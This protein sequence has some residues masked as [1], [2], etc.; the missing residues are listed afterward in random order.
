MFRRG[1]ICAA[2]VPLPLISNR[3]QTVPTPRIIDYYKTLAIPPD[4]DLIGVENAYVRLSDELVQAAQEEEAAARSLQVLNEAY[5]VLSNAETRREYDRLLFAEEYA[6]LER[7]LRA[8]LRRRAIARSALVA[9]LG[10]IVLGQAAILAYV[11]RD[12][13]T[14]AAQVVL[15]PLFPGAA[16]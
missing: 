12:I 15:G 1:G 14:D 4:A 7:R 3:G 16:G 6:A 10:L 5:S 8:E 13:V 2:R 11:G 9:A